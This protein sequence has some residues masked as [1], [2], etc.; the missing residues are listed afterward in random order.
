[1]LTRIEVDKLIK[2][3]IVIVL[4]LCGII[5][6]LN[7][8]RWQD[9]NR[10]L[11]PNAI[12]VTYN[13]R[14]TALGIRYSHLFKNPVLALPLGFYGSFSHTIHPDLRFINYDWERKYSIGG[15]VT[16]PYDGGMHT[17]FTL[18]AVRNEHPRLNAD[19]GMQTGQHN[20]TYYETNNWG[21]DIGIQVQVNHFTSHLTVDAINFMRYVQFGVGFTFYKLKK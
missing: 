4:L 21:V 18:G 13:G 19:Y 3:L 14:N 2:L 5:N 1:M 9:E 8:Q 11:Y 17:M 7:A 20:P 16:L 12:Q 6:C 10:G 15:M